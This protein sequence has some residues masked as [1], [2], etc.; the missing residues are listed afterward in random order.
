MIDP[1]VASALARVPSGLFIMTVRNQG[2]STGMLASWVQQAGFQPLAVT[3]AVAHGRF[4]EE[5]LSSTGRFVLNQLGTTDAAFLKHFGKGFAPGESA[6][7]GIDLLDV[8]EGGPVLANALAYLDCKV[9]GRVESADHCIFVAEVI[10]GEL[11]KTD[12]SPFVHTRR[13]ATHY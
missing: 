3:V 4:F 7:E 10:G 12:G 2:Q 1:K 13:S 6:F 9:T 5:W 11:L 8:A